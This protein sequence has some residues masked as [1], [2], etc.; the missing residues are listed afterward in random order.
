MHFGTEPGNHSFVKS[1]AENI[2]AQLLAFDVYLKIPI[3]AKT[4]LFNTAGLMKARH[5]LVN[6]AK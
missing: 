6:A 3:L 1:K 4:L 2:I 5:R